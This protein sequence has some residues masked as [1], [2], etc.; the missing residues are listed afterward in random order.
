M[1][2]VAAQSALVQLSPDNVRLAIADLIWLGARHARWW[3]VEEADLR[4]MVAAILHTLSQ[5]HV[6]VPSGAKDLLAWRA[7]LC[8][9]VSIMARGMV[10]P[11][12]E[13]AEVKQVVD[14][15]KVRGSST[16]GRG[17]EG[18]GCVV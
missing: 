18:R 10:A 5:H 12:A 6:W 16:G 7:V 9:M 1:E 3:R 2:G 4:A 8:E 14:E 13:V 15:W 11:S 17:R